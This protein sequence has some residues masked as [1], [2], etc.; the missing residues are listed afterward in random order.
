MKNKIILILTIVI[1]LVVATGVA[2]L[3]YNFYISGRLEPNINVNGNV[4]EIPEK[5]P[6]TFEIPE[7]NLKN[8]LDFYDPFVTD[9]YRIEL[10]SSIGFYDEKACDTYENLLPFEDIPAQ[11]PNLTY[12]NFSVA[13]TCRN[14]HNIF[15]YLK[16]GNETNL[17]AIST[18]NAR[19]TA[20][21]IRANNPDLCPGA[22]YPTCALS[23]GQTC[24]DKNLMMEDSQDG[25]LL[26]IAACKYINFVNPIYQDCAF[27]NKT[28]NKELLTEAYSVYENYL[29]DL[30][31]TETAEYRLIVDNKLTVE[32]CQKYDPTKDLLQRQFYFR[33]LN[34]AQAEKNYSLEELQR[35]IAETNSQQ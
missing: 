16:T 34:F 6:I 9:K 5:Q 27:D 11:D 22:E 23:F 2:I 29:C 30:F 26:K 1:L 13:D 21:A 12:P 18:E 17:S 8:I 25:D 31:H 19:K 4:N 3:A 33:C 15:Q 7:W 35:L 10:Y 14:Q 24:L 28:F 20:M 32:Y